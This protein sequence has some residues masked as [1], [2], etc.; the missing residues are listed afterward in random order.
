MYKRK[1]F[2]HKLLHSNVHKSTNK[3]YGGIVKTS[4]LESEH[5]IS[6]PAIPVKFAVS[7]SYW[8]M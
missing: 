1:I 6:K 7:K 2:N 4:H 3:R 5:N 8:C